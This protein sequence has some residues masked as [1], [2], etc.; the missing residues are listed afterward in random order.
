MGYVPALWMIWV[1]TALVV[2]LAVACLV[3]VIRSTRLRAKGAWGAGCVIALVALAVAYLTGF[4]FHLNAPAPVSPDAM[5]YLWGKCQCG[6]DSPVQA[7]LLAV[8][9]RDGTVQWRYPLRGGG[10]DL[11]PSDTF[12]SDAQHVYVQQQAPDA[13]SAS[14]YV[15]TALD[16]HS[17]RQVWQASSAAGARLLSVADGQLTLSNFDTTLILDTQTGR[18]VL[19]VS[20]GDVALVRDGTLYVCSGL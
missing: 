14:A 9:V 5:V 15:V 8:R 2:L 16:V 1:S 7:A 3:G 12:I 13:T 18:E 19:R 6:P 10:N 17:G 4:T 11:G 20:L